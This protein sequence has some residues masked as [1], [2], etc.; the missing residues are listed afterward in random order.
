MK[1][2]FTTF[3]SIVLLAIV[4]F[5]TLAQA[6]RPQ[7]SQQTRTFVK[8]D[9]AVVAL[10]NARVID[11]TGAPVRANQT[12]LIRDGKIAAI[13]AAGNVPVPEGATVIDLAGKSV[14]PGLV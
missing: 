1:T 5:V 12:L 2:R 10:T 8:V 4:I 13:G 6:Q 7:L 11:G 14:M 3:A 9:A